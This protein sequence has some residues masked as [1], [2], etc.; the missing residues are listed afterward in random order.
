MVG[1]LFSDRTHQTIVSDSSS[2]EVA[3]VGGVI[4]GSGI[5]PVAFLM[6]VNDLVKLHESHGIA[7]KIIFCVKVYS[8]NSWH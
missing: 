2:P 7:V 8:E 6:Y 4:Q 5:G 1:A 3:L